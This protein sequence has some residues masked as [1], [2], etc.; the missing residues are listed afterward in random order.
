MERKMNLNIIAEGNDTPEERAIIM[1][2]FEHML[3][4]LLKNEKIEPWMT[5]VILANTVIACVLQMKDEDQA[6]MLGY[7]N[8]TLRLAWISNKEI[9]ALTSEPGTG[10]PN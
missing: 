6:Q 5:I 10:R 3:E 9:S 8:E 7:F 1:P 2:V 4:T